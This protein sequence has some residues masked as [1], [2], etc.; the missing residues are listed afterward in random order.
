MADQET[1]TESSLEEDLASVIDQMDL[2][3]GPGEEEETHR[4][5][6]EPE[7]AEA[8]AEVP[9]EEAPEGEPEQPEQ[10]AVRLKPPIDWS[11][12]L[13]NEF[14]NLKPEVQQA[15]HQ[16]EV[17]ISNVLQNTAHE[18]RLAQ[19]FNNVVNQYRGLMAAEGVQD[20]LQGVQ[21][22][23]MTTAQL[24]MGSKQQKAAK[25]AD[26]IKHYSIDI[27][28]LDT[29]LAGQYQPNQEDNRLEQMLNQRLAPVDQLLQQ[30]NQQRQYQY[31]QVENDAYQTIEQFGSDPNNEF[32]DDVRLA[33][34]DFLDVAAQ[35]NQQMSLQ[36]AYD[37]ACAMNPEIAQ[38]MAQRR[39]G[40]MA[41]SQSQRLAQ[42]R[43]A[44]S[45]IRG[46]RASGG[47][48]ASADGDSIRDI[49]ESQLS[50]GGRV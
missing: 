38:I 31:Q 19:S 26:L 40:Q 29:M 18:R 42:K 37:R 47:A 4:P 34:A 43:G 15:I 35:R 7:E 48:T 49:L 45:S 11:P 50:G 13:K 8:E 39:S 23:L 28:T 6:A 5:E 36:E 16:R 41:Q 20:P 1:Q 9:A 44:A 17:A 12:S 14:K 22:L 27:E 46:T 30:L 25:I 24:A 32:F 33:M 3:D 2:E 10:P 21:G